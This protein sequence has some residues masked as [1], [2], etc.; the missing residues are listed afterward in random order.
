MPK[1]HLPLLWVPGTI[2]G[3]AA[4]LIAGSPV[5]AGAQAA[6]PS[7][8]AVPI[9]SGDNRLL[10]LALFMVGFTLRY[11][12][13]LWKRTYIATHGDILPFGAEVCSI[14]E[15]I[16]EGRGYST[17]FYLHSGPTSWI[18]PL[19][20]YTMALLFRIFGVWSDASALVMIWLQ[21]LMAAATGISICILGTRTLGAKVGFWSAWI[22]AVSP[23]FFRWPVSWI[24]DFTASALLVSVTML[25]T[26]DAAEQGTTKSWLRLGA[27]WGLTALT[28][29]APLSV[30]PVTFL[31]AGYANYKAGQKWIRPFVYSAALFVA[32]ISP[33][34]VRN[35]VVFQRP[36]FLRSNYWF[37]FHLGNYH[38]SNGIGFSGK[39]PNNNR[40]VLLQYLNWGEPRF[41]DY[42]KKD[43]FDF[44]REY[45]A[46]FLD[47]T[48]H[49]TWWYWDGTS[50]DYYGPPEW[51]VP[52]KFWPLSLLGW[53][54]FL[55]VLT[56]RPRGWLLFSA[57][58]LIYPI[59]YYLAYPSVK[60][61]H[62]IEP[63]LLLLAVYLAFV[64]R[65]EIVGRFK[66]L[67]S[68][69]QTAD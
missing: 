63:E 68:A 26:L 55:F 38:F 36:V 20:P 51:W 64:V 43:S 57:L 39:H 28:N 29:P 27:I 30:M 3:M 21:C 44:I 54:G 48:L 13:A 66:L 19:Y 65:G 34:L 8:D 41:I 14:A 50:L 18:A 40:K 5:T 69:P 61:R 46:E 33:W 32:I 22:W 49:R 10:Y 7:A 25:F 12:F 15:S 60:Y 58:L 45:P 52:W 11:G 24:W 16:V 23:I 67:Q 37:E 42:Y 9:Q 17:P 6:P 47:L 53:L 35:Y 1:H 62:A 56:R 4:T 59:P 31:Y 2:V